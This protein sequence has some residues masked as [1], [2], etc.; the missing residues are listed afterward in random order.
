MASQQ[1]P[2]VASEGLQEPKA[3]RLS[4]LR[5]AFLH[6]MKE[7]RFETALNL[8]QSV[9]SLDPGNKLM[10]DF[11]PVLEE[12]LTLDAT[13]SEDEAGAPGA[14]GAEAAG[15]S[16]D[17]EDDDEDDDDDE[18]EDED[19]ED[20]DE[21]EEEDESAGPHVKTIED[22]ADG[23]QALSL[24][25]ATTSQMSSAAARRAIRQGLAASIAKLREQ[26]R[27]QKLMEDDPL[28]A[29]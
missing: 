7:Q 1:K 3:K 10:L 27:L 22:V 13:E 26:E 29:A 24:D 18:D 21:S 28:L 15:E 20:E 17:D 12:K 25:P 16:D 5:Q 6:A 19:D 14:G 2:N 9:L 4:E 8:A 23:V 11:I